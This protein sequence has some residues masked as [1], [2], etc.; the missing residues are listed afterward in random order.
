ML[1]TKTEEVDIK[2]ILSPFYSF[3][4]PSS[5]LVASH[6]KTNTETISIL[7]KGGL[8]ILYNKYLRKSWVINQTIYRFLLHFKFPKTISELISD[9][10]KEIKCEE[11]EIT[12]HVNL[13][14]SKMT[15]RKILIGEQQLVSHNDFL[16]KYNKNKK[17]ERAVFN[18]NDQFNHYTIKSILSI[19][20][21][22]QLFILEDKGQ[23]SVLKMFTIPVELPQKIQ[24]TSRMKFIKEFKLL[25]SL[26]DHSAI[27]QLYHFNEESKPY[28]IMEYIQGKSL[29]NFIL[30]GVHQLRTKLQLL[31]SA[32]DTIAFV[33]EKGILHGDIHNGN[34]IVVD[35]NQIKLIDFGL[36]NHVV[37]EEGE[38][39]RNGA[40][41]SFV[42]P[43]RVALNSFSFLSRP[44]DIRS[45]VFQLG[46]LGYFILYQKMPFCGLTWTE[47][48]NNIK[49]VEPNFEQHCS[50][51]EPIPP[52]IIQVLRKAMNKVPELRYANAR[53]L[54]DTINKVIH[55]K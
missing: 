12:P 52:A 49:T 30:K 45:E 55:E 19:R 7:K 3:V 10:A 26:K 13:F 25:A 43:E 41:S 6:L 33:Q 17:I 27:C 51:N 2:Y 11:S 38:I 15:Y 24:D 16:T 48:A 22:T 32:V 23:L 47:L 14:L 20:K 36:S 40:K 18:V 28:A 29:R 54:S 35:K 1:N 21:E 5:K 44:P 4:E 46:V 31:S 50:N 9:F 37:Y 42:P 39:I 34:F 53:L 8:M